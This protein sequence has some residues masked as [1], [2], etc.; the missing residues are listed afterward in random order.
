MLC[1]HKPYL[2]WHFLPQELQ[3]K[4]VGVAADYA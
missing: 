1:E 2:L 4:G 3:T